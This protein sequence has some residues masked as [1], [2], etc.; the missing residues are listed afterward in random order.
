MSYFS[1][2]FNAVLHASFL[3][4]MG[5]ILSL[6]VFWGQGNVPALPA[7]TGRGKHLLGDPITWCAVTCALVCQLL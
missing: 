7:T 1:L 6:A 4:V 2:T 3:R 5:R